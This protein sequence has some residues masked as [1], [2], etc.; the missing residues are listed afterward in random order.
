MT[1]NKSFQRIVKKLRFLPSAEFTRYVLKTKEMNQKSQ[2]RSQKIIGI[3]AKR[4]TGIIYDSRDPFTFIIKGHLLVDAFVTS[5]IDGTFLKPSKLNLDR[6]TYDTKISLCVAV[7]LIHDE[8]MPVLQKLGKIRNRFAHK[9]WLSLEKKEA[10]D[11]IN[12]LRQSQL[13]RARF[14]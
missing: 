14:S 8:V 4:I 13:L 11:F 5:I 1:P 3:L 9:L 10:L 6:F 7:G 2:T 12:T